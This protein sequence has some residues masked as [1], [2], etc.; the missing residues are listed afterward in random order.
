MSTAPTARH[1]GV[2]RILHG[3][4]MLA[5]LWQLIGSN[6]IQRPKVGR[7]ANGM[8]EAHEVVGLATLGLVVAFWIWALVRRGETP[9]GALFPWFSAQRLKAVKDDAVRYLRA[10]RLL[11]L[12]DEGDNTPLASATHGLGLLAALAMGSSGAWLF[13]MAIPGGTVMQFHKFMATFMWAYV[14]GHA[15]LALLHQS[16]GHPVLQRM[17]GR[18]PAPA[19]DAPAPQRAT[20]AGT[21][22]H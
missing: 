9:V 17:F 12:P 10:A 13:T 7:V 21:H 6:F 15:G 8:Y 11:S 5:V 22:G 20:Q 18:L 19:A 16:L 3:L 4:L 2:T 14:V 1:S